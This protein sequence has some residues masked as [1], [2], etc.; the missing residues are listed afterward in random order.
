MNL[1]YGNPGNNHGKHFDFVN[2]RY[3]LDENLE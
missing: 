2:L 1:G 3:H